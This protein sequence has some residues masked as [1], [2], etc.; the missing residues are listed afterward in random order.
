MPKLSH[1]NTSD[2]LDEIELARTDEEFLSIEQYFLLNSVMVSVGNAALD[3]S[4]E[5]S[6]MANFNRN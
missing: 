6:D 4:A 1:I 5:V 2:L 3:F